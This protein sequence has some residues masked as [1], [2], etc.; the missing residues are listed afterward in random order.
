MRV[1]LFLVATNLR[2]LLSRTISQPIKNTME[3]SFTLPTTTSSGTTPF[4]PSQAF[5]FQAQGTRQGTFT[6]TG[7]THPQHDQSQL[8]LGESH[9]DDSYGRVAQTRA[10]GVGD[11]KQWRQRIISHIE[12]R[13]KDKRAS[14]Q[15]SRRAGLNGPPQ[16]HHLHRLVNS[17]PTGSLLDMRAA[18]QEELS[19]SQFS[20]ASS[21]GSDKITPEEE[22]VWY[23]LDFGTWAG[24][25]ML[26]GTWTVL[27]HWYSALY[28]YQHRG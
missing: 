14:L 24:S 6:S 1:A 13:I 21:V 25:R 19:F 9:G 20:H 16:E 8:L 10:H 18:S 3:F 11:T 4:Q 23:H 5:T 7:A 15:N 17:T 2:S 28:I 12:D 27:M 26:W 22:R